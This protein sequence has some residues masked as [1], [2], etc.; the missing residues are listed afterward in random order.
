VETCIVSKKEILIM[1]FATTVKR[2]YKKKGVLAVK[3]LSQRWLDNVFTATMLTVMFGI[4]L[5]MT[6]KIVLRKWI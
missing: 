3:S 6:A 5:T 4:T 1:V 2:F